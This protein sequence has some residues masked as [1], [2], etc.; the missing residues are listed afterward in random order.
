MKK[1]LTAI[2]LS[3]MMMSLFAPLAMAKDDIIPDASKLVA[4]ADTEAPADAKSVKATAGNGEVT[5]TWNVT[6]DNVAVKGYKIYY[7]TSSV[8]KE[9]DDYTLGPIDAGN[10]IRYTITGLTNGTKYYFA[11]TAYD[12]AGNESINY[13]DEVS[14]TPAQVSADNEPPKVAKTEAV[15]KT[16]VRIT[17]SEAV[18][19]P[20]LNPQS[21]FNIK[22]D[23]TQAIL[24]VTKVE[25]DASDPSKKAVLL[26]T[27]VQQAG[28]TY[29][30]TVGIQ[31]KDLADNPIVSGTSD[32]GFFIGSSVT[33]VTPPATPVVTPEQVKPAASTQQALADTV[34]P[35][36]ISV[37]VPNTTHLEV[38]FSEP[39]VISNDPSAN[40]IITEE[41][42]IENTLDVTSS[43]LSPDQKKVT[44]TTAVQK[45]MNYNLIVV[46][47]KD[48]AGNMIGVD[49]NATVFFG[50]LSNEETDTPTE[51]DISALT[52]QTPDKTPPEDVTNLMAELADKMVKL[53]WTGSLN[54]AGDLI[55]YVLYKSTDG[56]SYGKGT[57]IDST[58][59]NYELS[60]LVPG[61]TYFFKVTAKDAKGNESMG[62]VT[63]L[64]LP[65]TGPELGLLLL[66]SLGIGR[67]MKKAKKTK[68]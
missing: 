60:K 58:A 30:V 33:N 66:G 24:P 25:M 45:A 14:S 57:S 44:L 26:T 17:F 34:S 68:K 16:L 11:V 47:V 10:K 5:L 46:E 13:S 9:G 32:T 67:L 23:T 64:E 19:L 21:A 53:N 62:A 52:Q 42:N 28:A 54:T 15:I 1:T 29:L 27:G 55:N 20:S 31:I 63:S 43:V 65:C 36:L 48:K 39:V 40:F 22:N 59:V 38:T 12:A 3:L 51:D 35:E 41:N 50:G 6:T 4:Q 49:S 61:M 37:A 18:K 7:G 56:T 8:A 2:F